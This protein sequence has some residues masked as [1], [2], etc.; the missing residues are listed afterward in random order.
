MRLTEFTLTITTGVSL[1]ECDGY[2]SCNN[3]NFN[4]S[5]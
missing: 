1:Y 2:V 3:G 5:N 4:E